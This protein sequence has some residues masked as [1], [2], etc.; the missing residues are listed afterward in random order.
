[1]VP[2]V[3]LTN[4]SQTTS[5]HLIDE[6]KSKFVKKT[7]SRTHARARIHGIGEKSR[8]AQQTNIDT[9]DPANHINREQVI[10]EAAR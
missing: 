3:M 8:Q 9:N 2:N 6:L 4:A 10:C 1:M 5:N 7:H